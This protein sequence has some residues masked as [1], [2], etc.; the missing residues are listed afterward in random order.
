MEIKEILTRNKPE[1]LRAL[2]SFSLNDTDEKILL[3]FNLWARFFYVQYFTSN[4]ALFHKMIDSNNLKAYRGNITSFVDVAFRGAA[5]TSRIKLFIAFCIANDKNHFRRYIKILSADLD[6]A[7]QITTDI[8]NMFIQKRFQTVYP[9]IFV[10]DNIKREERM[11]SFTTST[12]IK[13]SAGT[14]GTDQRG[15]LQEDARPDFILFEDFETRKTLRSAKTSKAIWD[16]MEEARTALSID[17][18]CI[19]NCN[20]ISEMGNVHKLVTNKLSSNK[21]V[22]IIPI[23]DNG[24]PAWD[25][26]S[27]ADIKQMEIDDD[28][29]EGERLCK[30]SASRDIFFDRET[31][32]NMKVLNPF[33][34][35]ANFKIY[36]AFDA[37]HRY[38]SGHDVS[39]GVG[40]D[41]STSVFIDFDKVPCQVVGI[42]NT[43]I[44][45]PDNFGDEINRQAEIFGNCLVCPE[46]NNHGHATIAR[47]KQL[48][49]NIWIEV[50]DDIRTESNISKNYGW[51]TNAATKPKML[52]AL[53]KAI[54][55]G[56]L[57]L[58]DKD[59]IQEC[60][61]YSR[62]D[63]MDKEE[64]PR[65]VTRHFDLLM[66]CAIA[67]QM[68]D[69]AEVKEIEEDYSKFNY[70][71]EQLYPGIG[72]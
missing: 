18:A 56:L 46:R 36:K 63:L 41:S 35:I 12:G 53:S 52:Y 50:R 21:I 19:Y 48:E 45:K 13:I 3:K 15:A 2:F 8:Y 14:V 34:E 66:A 31:L 69:F 72:L 60:K 24:I 9:E 58:N 38:G 61:S 40:L 26:Y 65:L 51:N 20:Y 32:D 57:E 5:K 33:K 27:V 30:P 10:K 68:K 29:F 23:I 54:S 67:W 70:E 37:S 47:L 1:E 42:F 44:I 25:R 71:D 49:A 22:L 64:D 28:D 43:N 11:S 4:D 6:N 16:N 17:G 62:N 7:R 59:L 55:D 39:G